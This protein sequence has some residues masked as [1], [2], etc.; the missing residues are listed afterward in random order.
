MNKTYIYYA[1]GLAVLIGGYFLL[2]NV[3]AK[4]DDNAN[5]EINMDSATLKT[6]VDWLYARGYSVEQLPDD[7]KNDL[8]PEQIDTIRE[9]LKN[10]K[11]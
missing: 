10:R 1:L 8:T 4:S 9:A 7:V 2:V 5:S 6:F 3:K 11:P